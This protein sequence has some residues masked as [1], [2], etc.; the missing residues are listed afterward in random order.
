MEDLRNDGSS[1]LHI[2]SDLKRLILFLLDKKFK[3][4]RRIVFFWKL[5]WE[6]EYRWYGECWR[7]YV[8]QKIC[9][10]LIMKSYKIRK[11][12]ALGKKRKRKKEVMV[13]VIVINYL[14]RTVTEADENMHL[15]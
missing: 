2:L 11:L 14:G 12:S 9:A 13:S 5:W 3:T 10:G 4:R 7:K 15:N 6:V 1:R 8:E